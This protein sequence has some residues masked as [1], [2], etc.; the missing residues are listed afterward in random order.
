VQKSRN[1][2]ASSRHYF[3]CKSVRKHIFSCRST[4]IIPL[5][6]RRLTA[7]RVERR[8]LHSSRG[9]YKVWVVI[10]RIVWIDASS[11]LLVLYNE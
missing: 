3:D 9:M 5:S 4:V 6:H 7:G 2:V 11:G 10:D 1:A 8:L